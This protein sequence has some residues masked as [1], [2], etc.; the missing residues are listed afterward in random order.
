VLERVGGADELIDG[1]WEPL[2]DWETDVARALGEHY[3]TQAA[4]HWE[5][6]FRV[7]GRERPDLHFCLITDDCYPA[8]LRRIFN[9]PPFITS[10]GRWETSDARSVAVV[11]TR[12]PTAEGSRRASRLASGLAERG[13]TVVSGLAA[14]IDAAAHEAALSAGG[15]T[16]A[17]LGHGLL[18]PAYPAV[19]RELAQR[20]AHQGALISQFAPMTPPTKF[21]FP[22][23][24]VVTSGIARGTAVVE[25]SHTSGARLQARLAVEHG[26][27]VWLLQ[28]LVD[29]FDWAKKFVDRY[30]EVR[31]VSSIDEI[32]EDVDRIDDSHAATHL[33]AVP[34]VEVARRR[35]APVVQPSSQ[36][37]LFSS[38]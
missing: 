11:G 23:R 3:S 28:S 21:T 38:A 9:P 32:L 17:I 35:R 1:Y 25:A 20:I 22:M 4:H 8:P 29:Q 27:L 13:V 7:W 37:S 31:V 30:P 6:R 34:A 12:N 5:E 36:A 18:R 15:R 26:K 14:G 10:D 16:L 24:N 19:N 33:P 2:D